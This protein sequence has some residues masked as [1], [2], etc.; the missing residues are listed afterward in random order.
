MLSSLIAALALAQ[1]ATTPAQKAA[2]PAARPRV[3]T[4]SPEAGATTTG[5][6]YTNR[7]FGFS[8]T[9]PQN[10]VWAGNEEMTAMRESTRRQ[11]E[12]LLGAEQGRAAVSGSHF[13]ALA[14]STPAGESV[15]VS[16]ES[17]TQYP[18]VK[19]GADYLANMLDNMGEAFEPLGDV[20]QVALAGRGF[21]RQRTR[22][23]VGDGFVF[24]ALTVTVVNHHALSFDC[25]GVSEAQLEEALETLDS[26]KF[27]ALPA[28]PVRSAPKKN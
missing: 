15:L 26:V 3:R 1:I 22:Q 17:L 23:K 10:W 24:H 19:T 13:L 9:T 2:P 27:S 4:V 6:T 11:T 28:G 14:T 16:A 18:E 7:Y 8:Y 25:V 21:W 20:Q 12:Q 5:H